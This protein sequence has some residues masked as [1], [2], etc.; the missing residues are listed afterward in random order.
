MGK[1]EAWKKLLRNNV[2]AYLSI[3]FAL[4]GFCIMAYTNGGIGFATLMGG[5]LIGWALTNI[6]YWTMDI[7]KIRTTNRLGIE[8]I[9][10]VEG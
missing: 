8:S 9:E 6:E 5:I 7:A 3:G 2:F 10:F 4:V 1:T